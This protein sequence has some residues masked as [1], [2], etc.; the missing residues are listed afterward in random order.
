MGSRDGASLMHP[1]PHPAL[2][3]ASS[4]YQPLQPMTWG[5]AASAL[6]LLPFVL[7]TGLTATYSV[8][9]WLL[10]LY[11]GLVPTALAFV[12]FLVGMRYTTAT[13]AS[14]I[15]LIEPLT[16]TVLAW[17]LF[18]ERLSQLGFVGGVVLLGAIMLLAWPE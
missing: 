13:V 17:L 11:L 4:Q 7:A 6:M 15:T 14:I 8:T 3:Q 9:S 5:F 12:L 16:A 10:L 1:V 2:V 18:G